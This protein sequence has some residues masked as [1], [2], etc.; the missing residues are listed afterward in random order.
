VAPAFERD[1]VLHTDSDVGGVDVWL[2]PS[3]SKM[4]LRR[5]KSLMT[6]FSLLKGCSCSANAGQSFS[7]PERRSFIEID[8]QRPFARPSTDAVIS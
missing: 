5:F 6:A 3:S 4:L 1:H 7:T 8:Q 2:N